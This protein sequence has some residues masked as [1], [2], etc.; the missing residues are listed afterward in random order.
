M[1]KTCEEGKKKLE[2]ISTEQPWAKSRLHVN[3]RALG[4]TWTP[5]AGY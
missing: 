5:T 3:Y 2:L 1:R 4:T